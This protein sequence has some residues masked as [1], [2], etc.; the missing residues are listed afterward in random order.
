MN[1][2][3]CAASKPEHASTSDSFVRDRSAGTYCGRGYC[4]KVD[5]PVYQNNSFCPLGVWIKF[6]IYCSKGSS[7][8]PGHCNVVFIASACE[9]RQILTLKRSGSILS[10][11]SCF[12]SDAQGRSTSQNCALRTHC[13]QYACVH[14]SR[15]TLCH[16]L[17]YIPH[18]AYSNTSCRRNR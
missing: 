18:M 2:V 9:H 4:S 10:I 11:S 8:V 13:C 5:K 12:F 7:L 16:A 6:I 15:K 14:A 17:I 1:I 3:G